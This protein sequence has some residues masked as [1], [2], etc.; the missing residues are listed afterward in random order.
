MAYLIKRT[1]LSGPQRGRRH[2]FV[3]SRSDG[4]DNPYFVSEV[5]RELPEFSENFN[6]AMDSY[7]S[8]PFVAAA[9]VTSMDDET[10]YTVIGPLHGQGGVLCI[11]AADKFC[12]AYG[13]GRIYG[14]AK[15]C[16]RR[17]T[18]AKK[19]RRATI[20]HFEKKQEQS[21]LEQ[22]RKHQAEI[23]EKAAHKAAL[24][25]WIEENLSDIEKKR[26]HA[27]L[28]SKAELNG[29]LRDEVF[30]PL[31]HLFRY[32]RITASDWTGRPNEEL[33]FCVRKP[34]GCTDSQFLKLE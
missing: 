16:M 20:E 10:V 28:M 7:Q 32:E 9:V 34:S 33:E 4:H 25:E 1:A 14:I 12:F 6:G 8:P 3:S 15:G 2:C 21:R 30:L 13:W 29:M 23:A 26:Y 17:A 24:L 5:V 31:E 27:G 11:E 19:A 18:E 22:D